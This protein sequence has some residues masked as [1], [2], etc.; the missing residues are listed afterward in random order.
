MK[1]KRELEKEIYALQTRVK[2]TKE[3]LEK[4]SEQPID[5]RIAEALHNKLCHANHIDGCGWDYSNWNN[6][7]YTRMSYLAKAEALMDY[8]EFNI[9]TSTED[10]EKFASS[11]EGLLEIL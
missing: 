4:I 3:E 10:D 9:V 8:I 2:E 1:T 5:Q 7:C 6:P 11:I